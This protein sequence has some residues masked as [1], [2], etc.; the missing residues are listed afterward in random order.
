MADVEA[1]TKAA[2]QKHN[3]SVLIAVPASSRPWQEGG[4]SAGYSLEAVTSGPVAAAV[5]AVILGAS[6]AVAAC[7]EFFSGTKESATVT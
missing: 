1:W 3:N 7:V 2:R 5:A 6:A 4:A